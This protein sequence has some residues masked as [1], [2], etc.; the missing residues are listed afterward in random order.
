[1]SNPLAT[2]HDLLC[3]AADTIERVALAA[4]FLTP[5]NKEN[6]TVL[7]ESAKADAARL[8]TLAEQSVNGALKP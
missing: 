8:R 4:V 3:R 6:N 7:L 2:D 5:N 1:M